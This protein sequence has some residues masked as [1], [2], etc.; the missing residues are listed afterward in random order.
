[1]IGW[2]GEK[3][4]SPPFPPLCSLSGFGPGE[5]GEKGRLRRSKRQSR[6]RR[7]RKAAR[8]SPRLLLLAWRPRERFCKSGG[9]GR[10][11]PS[12][13]FAPLN[14][15]GNILLRAETYFTA[16]CVCTS[17]TFKHTCLAN[18]ETNREGGLEREPEGQQQEC[19]HHPFLND[20]YFFACS[21]Y[22]LGGS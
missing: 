11:S 21:K 13:N 18:W 20:L 6:K 7:G 4:S 8:V 10:N 1:M 5:G 16:L 22:A 9:G 3:F 15:G 2:R 17:K 12:E 19:T 14:S